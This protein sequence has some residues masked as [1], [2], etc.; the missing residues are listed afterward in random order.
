VQEA[1]KLQVKVFEEHQACA[2]LATRRVVRLEVFQE[3]IDDFLHG[4]EAP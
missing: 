1:K 4:D 2:L 3:L